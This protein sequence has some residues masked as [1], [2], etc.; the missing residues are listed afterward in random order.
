MSDR[1]SAVFLVRLAALFLAAA[2]GLL[3]LGVPLL[4]LVT[5]DAAEFIADSLGL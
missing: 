2:G 1:D 4:G 3:Y 5:R